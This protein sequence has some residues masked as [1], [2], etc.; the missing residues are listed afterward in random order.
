LIVE[1]D[2][3]QLYDGPT[4]TVNK[5]SHLI[6]NYY[7]LEEAVEVTLYYRYITHVGEE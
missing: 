3:K 2:W 4:Y 5:L 6:T 7:Q 1:G